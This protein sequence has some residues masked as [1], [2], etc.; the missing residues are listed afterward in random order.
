MD[1][2]VEALRPALAE[3]LEA[4]CDLRIVGD[5]ERQDDIAAQFGGR[6][7]YPRKQLLVLVGEGQFGAFAVHGFGDAA[8]DRTLAGDSGDQ[9]ALALQ[10]THV[11][12]PMMM[13]W[14][15]PTAARLEQGL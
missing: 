3:L 9:C 13:S 11:L 10:E 2:D 7:L 8:G 14:R 6:F 5:V 12:S 15:C 4:R 1:E